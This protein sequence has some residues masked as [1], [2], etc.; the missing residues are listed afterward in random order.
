VIYIGKA[1]YRVSLLGGSSDLDWFVKNNGYGLCL[2]YSLDKYSYSILNILPSIA[3]NGILEYST[4]EEYKF[5]DEIAHPIVR[6]V[7]TD[8]KISKYI[9]LKTFGFASGGS[10]LGGS[11]SFLI[12]LISSLSKAFEMNLSKQ[13]IIEK[14]CFLEIN[15]LKKPIGK[16]DQ[17]LC[18]HK[19]FS[20]FT[21]FDNNSA[22]RN[23]LSKAKLQTLTRLC[24]DFFLIPTNKKR[25]SDSVL[26]KIK[27]HEKS[28]DRILQIRDI[29]EKFILFDDERDYK[30]EELFNLS[31]RESWAIKKSLSPVMS[32]S[33][34]D[35]YEQINKLVPNNW[36]RLL[37]AGSGGYFLIS[38]KI[39][40]SE[41][42][43][44]AHDNSLK[45]IFK[46]ELARENI[47]GCQI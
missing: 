36:I 28:N 7:L 13:E 15:I 41:L 4:R 39:N 25:S 29:A 8:L 5:I 27:S 1:P 40:S 44:L 30:I 47:V 31:V 37:G 43:N 34:F 9:E 35:Q 45:G 17:Y 18:G 42:N 11:S 33:L 3:K 24:Q 32:E 10:G 2:G 14:A 12:S 38:S 19:G 23:E 46:A 21:F 6:T 16:Q 26:S 20:S 22:V